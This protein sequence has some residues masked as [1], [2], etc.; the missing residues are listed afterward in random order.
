MS[1]KS[2]EKSPGG[3]VEV[4]VNTILAKMQDLDPS[5]ALPSESEFVRE[6]GV[7]RT[8]VR[9]AFRSLAA[10]QLIDLNSGR[11]ATVA[12][13]RHDAMSMLIRHGVSTEQL[14]LMQV[15]DVRKSVEIRAAAL[16]ALHRSDAEAQEIVG[17]AAGMSALEDDVEKTMRHDLAFHAAIARASGN[18]LLVVVIN[19][20][21]DLAETFWPRSWHWRKPDDRVAIIQKHIDLAAAIEGG[22]AFASSK[23]MEEHFADSVRVMVDAGM[24]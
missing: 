1:A 13:L 10:L 22:D 24:Y 2:G 21:L 15:Y 7:S 4:V 6:L 16:A 14:T 9:E 23:L 20:I 5:D 8:V 17:H 3:R 18:P 19:A 12:K 11:R